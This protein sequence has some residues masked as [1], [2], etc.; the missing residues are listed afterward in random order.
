MWRP[1]SWQWFSRA[2]GVLIVLEE[3]WQRSS[4]RT[5]DQGLIVLAAGLFG[6]GW[7]FRKNGGGGN[8]HA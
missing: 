7:L 2:L 5:V 3:L 4:G 6:V 1:P 8:G